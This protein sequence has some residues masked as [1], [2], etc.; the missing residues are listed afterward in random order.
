VGKLDPTISLGVTLALIVGG[1][2][3][4]LWKTKNE[5]GEAK[6]AIG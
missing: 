3:F 4:S 6:Q 1:V 5:A 2:A